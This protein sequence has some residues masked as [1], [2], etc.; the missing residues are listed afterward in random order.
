M[1][2]SITDRKNDNSVNTKAEA[3][4]NQT[5]TAFID[6]IGETVRQ[7]GQDYNIYNSVLIAHA[8]LKSNSGQSGLSQA[9]YYNFFGIKGSYNGNFVTMRTWEDDG[10]GNIYEIDEPFRLYG[11]LSDSLEDYATLMTS[12]TYSGTCKS[13]TSSYA[14]ATQ[15]LTGTYAT[16]SLYASKLNSI[17]TYL[18]SIITYYGL[19]IY[20]QAPVTQATDSSSGLVWNSYRGSYTDTETLSIDEA[21]ASY[22]IINKKSRNELHPKS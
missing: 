1:L 4:Y 17:I 20:D 3:A 12:S 18:N 13:N 8:I 22:K 19:T 15:A 16:D 9:P 11:S 7:I 21:W 6:S 14:D 2:A 10:T 5:T